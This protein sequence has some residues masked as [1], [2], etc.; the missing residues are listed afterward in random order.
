MIHGMESPIG[1]VDYPTLLRRYLRMRYALCF[2]SLELFPCT[3]VHFHG[4]NTNRLSVQSVQS[5]V[6]RYISA[7]MAFRL[8][9]VSPGLSARFV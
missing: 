6:S 4:K 8:R 5:L 2:L 3:R 1:F 9:S 7:R